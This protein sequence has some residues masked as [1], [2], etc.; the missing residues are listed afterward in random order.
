MMRDFATGDKIY[1]MLS[2]INGT[3]MG[4]EINMLEGT[5]NIPMHR[6]PRR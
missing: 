4:G 6:T 5:K 3:D 1:S 2:V